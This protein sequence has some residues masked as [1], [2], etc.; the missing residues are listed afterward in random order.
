ME[1][2]PSEIIGEIAKYLPTQTF[3]KLFAVS[4]TLN[5][6]CTSDLIWK[7][8]CRYHWLLSESQLSKIQ[9]SNG[10]IFNCHI[11]EGK[12][13]WKQIYI[14]IYK[15]FPF[16]FEFL[17]DPPNVYCMLNLS[18]SGPTRPIWD[19]H[20]TSKDRKF[21][22]LPSSLRTS[23]SDESFEKLFQAVKSLLSGA[24]YSRI[25]LTEV[26]SITF[27]LL[28]NKKKKAPLIE[29][30]IDHINLKFRCLVSASLWKWIL[31]PRMRLTQKNWKA[32]RTLLANKK[33]EQLV[34]LGS[35]N[36]K[37]PLG[38]IKD[39]LVGQFQ[40]YSPSVQQGLYYLARNEEHKNKL[41]DILEQQNLIQSKS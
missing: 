7:N 30:T 1:A 19:P 41:Q 34:L 18:V 17:N 37:F 16:K 35:D 3:L 27:R 21:A 31:I 12:G 40:F 14:F 26:E 24:T 23:L 29:T 5:Q 2:L 15:T 39:F 22:A 6:K 10:K 28:Y 25:S 4:K 20:S 32:Q 38:T 11:K 9:D 36:R 13:F 33:I 8:C